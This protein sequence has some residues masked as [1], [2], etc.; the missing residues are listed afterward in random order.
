MR[1][2]YSIERRILSSGAA[3]LII[4]G[5]FLFWMVRW[6]AHNAAEEAFDRVLGAAA[7]SIADTVSIEDG[8]ASVDL[9]HS[10]FAILGT[11][12]L[13]RIFYRVAAPDGTIITG[14]PILG[15]EI[16]HGTGPQL[17]LADSTYRGERI[18]IAAVA[19]YS[20]D[21][22]GG[23]WVDVLVGETREARDQLGLHLT[24]NAA[25]PAIAVSV[26]AF[27]LIWL[28][29]R[30]AFAPLRTVEADLRHRASSDLSPV[31]G[32][33]PREVSA[34]IS[35]LNDFMGRLDSVLV[36]LKSVTADAAHQLRTPLTALRALAELS[37][38]EAPAG[39]LRDILGRIHA[40]SVNA[41]V[42]ANQLLSDAS[43]L[44]GIESRLRE[45]LD[46]RLVVRE[47]IRRLHAEGS[48]PAAA[49]M[50]TL[51]L[52]SNAVEIEAEAVS[53]REMIR[54]I[55]ENALVHAPGSID[56]TVT[57]VNR[58]VRF[59]VSDRGP[60]IPRDMRKQMF[61][62]FSRADNSKPGSGLGLAIARTVAE[63]MGG[64]ISLDD[65]DGGGLSVVVC[66]PKGGTPA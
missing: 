42:L 65:R 32:P 10:A 8:T 41:S 34:L 35:A 47:A 12:R 46:M 30:Q 11:S 63:A 15:L 3:L 23:G 60:G 5:L 44:H 27:L 16:P 2:D 4:I 50:F 59:V 58:L 17:R 62:R 18:R 20:T 54:N 52:P 14:S 26:L 43:T 53:L 33:V 55:I 22:A 38:D 37:I 9:P 13:N 25:L 29:V 57:E 21:A 64:S 19:R 45:T 49:D 61:E 6:N 28:A 40:N 51:N 24:F 1:S 56:I 7:L 39:R 36:G 66:L 31:S 48:Y